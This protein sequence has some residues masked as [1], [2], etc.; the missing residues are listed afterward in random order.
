MAMDHEHLFYRNN[1][2]PI[3]DPTR[4][5]FRA[6]PKFTTKGIL[7]IVLIRASRYIGIEAKVG[8]AVLSTD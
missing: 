5:A 1:N 3:F 2:V 8:K 6:M 7:D 4:Q